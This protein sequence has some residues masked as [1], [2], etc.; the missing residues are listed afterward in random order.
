MV[1]WPPWCGEATLAAP[2]PPAPSGPPMH[3]SLRR[4][5]RAGAAAALGSAALAAPAAAQGPTLSADSSTDSI[6]ATGIANGTTTLQ[7]L[8]RDPTT[9]NPVVIGQYTANANP[10]LPFTV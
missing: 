3:T 7:A 5:L 6:I 2:L 10:Y 4:C 1:Q 8:R 9:G